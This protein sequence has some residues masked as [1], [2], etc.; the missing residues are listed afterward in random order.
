MHQAWNPKS[1]VRLLLV[2]IGGGHYFLKSVKEGISYNHLITIVTKYI[3]GEISTDLQ[4]GLLVLDQA[5]MED[6]SVEVFL[7]YRSGDD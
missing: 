1:M 6:F 4:L 7:G 2:E 5:H 3:K